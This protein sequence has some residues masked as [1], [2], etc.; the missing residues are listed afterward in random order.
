MKYIYGAVTDA[1]ISRKVN[2]DSMCVMHLDTS[3]G[4]MIF[5]AVCDG[6]GGLS[7]GEL[8][9]AT[10]V[11]GF[12][13]WIRNGLPLLCVEG[14]IRDDQLREQWKQLIAR[15]NKKIYCYGKDNNI[16]LGTTVSA[17]LITQ[18]RYY[19]LNIGDSRIYQIH[20]YADQITTDHSLVYEEYLAGKISKMQVESDKR[21]NVLTRS[22]G[23]AMDVDADYFFG[24]IRTEATFFLCTDG[25]HHILTE[26]DLEDY[27]APNQFKSKKELWKILCHLNMMIK[28][29]MEEDNLT[30]A[31]VGVYPLQN[32]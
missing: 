12:R 8:A 28:E 24:K 19:C 20:D 15:L 17:I 13:E 22:V 21:N 23:V 26:A 32:T 6:M 4:E 5:A 7:Q 9:S 31:A 3:L 25:V 16:Y 18:T 27:L 30:L 10:V 29:Q 1:G 2:Q 14:G 11:E